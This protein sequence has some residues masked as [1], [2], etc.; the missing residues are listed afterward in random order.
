MK[1]EEEEMKEWEDG[2]FNYGQQVGRYEFK[3]QQ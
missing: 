2:A 3:S 1:Q